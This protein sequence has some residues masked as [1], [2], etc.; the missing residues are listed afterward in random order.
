MAAVMQ[1]FTGRAITPLV[2]ISEP[3]NAIHRQKDIRQEG[4]ASY[5]NQNGLYEIL[6]F[7]LIE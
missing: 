3:A 6:I 4:I 1:V 7:I 2:T 5:Q